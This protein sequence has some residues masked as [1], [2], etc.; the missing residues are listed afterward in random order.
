MTSSNAMDE[1]PDRD[2]LSL[3]LQARAIKPPPSSPLH[4]GVRRHGHHG[5]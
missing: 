5:W 3:P 1:T 4:L 2:L